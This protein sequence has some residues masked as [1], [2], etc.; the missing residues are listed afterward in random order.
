MFPENVKRFHRLTFMIKDI[1]HY[2][3]QHFFDLI[4]IYDLGLNA[5]YGFILF[6]KK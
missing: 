2:V 6:K 3:L 4:T 1:V 5:I